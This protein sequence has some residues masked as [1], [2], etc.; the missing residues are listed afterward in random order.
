LGCSSQ[1]NKCCKSMDRNRNGNR[2]R[3]HSARPSTKISAPR[4]CTDTST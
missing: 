3:R 2:L 4:R 1:K